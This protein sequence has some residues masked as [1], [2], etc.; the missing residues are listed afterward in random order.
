[1]TNHQSALILSLMPSELDVNERAW[2]CDVLARLE[3]NALPDDAWMTVAIDDWLS[4]FG[5]GVLLAIKPDNKD[6][7]SIL[8]LP[9]DVVIGYCLYQSVFELAEIHRIGTHQDHQRQGVAA[10]LLQELFVILPTLHAQNL[11]LEVR[12]DNLPALALYQKHG[13]EQIDVRKNYYRNQT[14]N[15]IDAII[16]QKNIA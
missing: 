13:F 4:Q 12:A 9:N 11:L 2:L 16:M 7:S 8:Q 10:G 14:G 15:A 3:Q 1:M 6:C 5:A